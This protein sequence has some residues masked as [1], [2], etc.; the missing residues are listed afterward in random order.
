MFY[1]DVFIE[2]CIIILYEH[3]KIDFFN[4]KQNSHVF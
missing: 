3:R 4:Q 1:I 2:L